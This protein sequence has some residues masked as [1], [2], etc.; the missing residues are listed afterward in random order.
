MG[1]QLE[2]PAVGVDQCMAL[3]ALDLL[4]TVVAAGAAGLGSLVLWLSI[5]AAEGWLRDQSV[6]GRA[7]PGDG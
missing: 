2:R 7:T 1:L 6:R 3:A 4:A 5:T